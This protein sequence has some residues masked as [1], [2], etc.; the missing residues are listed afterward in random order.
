[1]SHKFSHEENRIK[2]CATC[3]NKIIF[4]D[5]KP[6][7]FHI[8]ENQI[9]LIRKFVNEQFDIFNTKFPLSLCGT[10]RITLSEHENGKCT[11][12]KPT[13]PN[14]EDIQ[15]PKET[16]ANNDICN[17]YLCITARYCGHQKAKVGRGLKRQESKVINASN[18]LYGA[19]NTV[20][21]S[22]IEEIKN[23][24]R[25]SIHVCKECFQEI[26]RGKNHSCGAPAKARENI[27]KLVRKL[28]DQQQEQVAS[29][30]LREKVD[31]QTESNS[32]RIKQL[33]NETVLSTLG[34]KMRISINPKQKNDVIFEPD[35][36]DNFQNN[37][38][39][40][41]NQ[42]KKLT[43]FLR[44][45]AGKRSV[46]TYYAKHA[47]EKSKT[48][49]DVY[50]EGIFDFDT[51]NTTGKEKRPVVWADAEELLEAIINHRN[52]TGNII[53]K[54]MADG[55]QGF[56]K[57]SMTVL[58]ENYAPD[59]DRSIDDSSFDEDLDLP[60]KKRRLYSEGGSTAMKA[61]LTSVHR[62]IMLS[63]VPQVK[64]TYDNMKVL[65]D[66]IKI[67][68]IP[69]KFVCDFKL[70]LIV[71]G[72][73][74][75]CSMY[76]SPY[77]FVTLRDIRQNEGEQ[78]SNKHSK[79]E[80]NSNEQN[81]K[82]NIRKDPN[83]EMCDDI[84]KEFPRINNECLKLKTYGDLK[85]DYRRFCSIGKDKKRAKD[86]HSTVNPPLFD[87]D[88][89]VYVIQKCIIPELHIMQGFVNH[90]FWDGLVPLEGEEKALQ[91]PKKLKVIP[92]NYHSR[93]F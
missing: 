51:D 7:Y 70:L 19:S 90:L 44:S 93:I 28:P 46:P 8:T 60:I 22:K 79:E 72:Q 21:L 1:M 34:A 64:D 14:Y 76:P 91:W 35:K 3:G 23:E 75:A 33:N 80:E 13:M 29:S 15:L 30:I 17:C 65:F 56:L 57:I 43:N 27:L 85:D 24:P 42:M 74:T 9:N 66:L 49:E 16:R 78:N 86:C 92:K 71:N 68:N 2:V 36:L 6:K 32:E 87:E 69:F 40:S 63:I 88:D 58:P 50:K 11:R 5:K 41:L 18:G 81:Q 77:C 61:K 47:S 26:G 84:S 59:L 20:N 37:T 48:L 73:Q 53:V 38:G 31:I 83:D 45:A 4:G 12:P 55:G 67:N 25:R 54:V 89:N 52:L 39:A 82:G 62:L 10:C